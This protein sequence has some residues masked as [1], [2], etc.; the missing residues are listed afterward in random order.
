[1]VHLVELEAADEQPPAS[2]LRV[3]VLG[4]SAFT[5]LGPHCAHAAP[6]PFPSS[7]LPHSLPHPSEEVDTRQMQPDPSQPVRPCPL[8]LALACLDR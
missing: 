6:L 5:A 4:T 2:L 1:M 8:R 7:G 3:T